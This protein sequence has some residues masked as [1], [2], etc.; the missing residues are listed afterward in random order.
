[1]TTVNDISSWDMFAAA[2]LAGVSASETSGCNSPYDIAHWAASVA[3]SMLKQRSRRL[4]GYLAQ[5]V[6]STPIDTL[7]TVS[8]LV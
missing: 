5:E 2:A 4:A 1:M 6:N 7:D 8:D 3:D